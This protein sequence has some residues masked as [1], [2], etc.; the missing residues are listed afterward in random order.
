M[1]LMPNKISVDV[2]GAIDAM[3]DDNISNVYFFDIEKGEVCC[4]ESEK[5]GSDKKIKEI[6]KKAERYFK[7]PR[8]SKKVKEKWLKSFVEEMIS[9]EVLV[10]SKKMLKH[11]E[12]NYYD[13]LLEIIEKSEEGWIHGWVEWSHFDAY[14]IFEDWIY[15]LPVKIDDEWEGCEDCAICRAMASGKDS[16]PELSKAF[17]EENFINEA[18]DILIGKKNL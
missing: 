13:T 2:E 11:P 3:L 10:L 12:K 14:E 5:N 9:P 8:V 18:E 4:I 16:V 17:S 7:L 15:S 1:Y 6:S